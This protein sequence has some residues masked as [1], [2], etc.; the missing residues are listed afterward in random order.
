M[1][2]KVMYIKAEELKQCFSKMANQTI[3][4]T[5]LRMGLQYIRKNTKQDE[6]G[7]KTPKSILCEG[8]TRKQV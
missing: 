3:S 5:A 7:K 4:E 6:N 2:L 1:L 8:R